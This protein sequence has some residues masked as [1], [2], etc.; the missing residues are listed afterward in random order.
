MCFGSLSRERLNVFVIHQFSDFRSE[1][2]PQGFLT[3][4]E[5]ERYPVEAESARPIPLIFQL[6]RLPDK[7]LYLFRI[8]GR[9]AASRFI[10]R[11]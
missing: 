6:T 2:L 1:R 7:V 10:H 5:G 9:V 4:Q 11:H 8:L 3:R